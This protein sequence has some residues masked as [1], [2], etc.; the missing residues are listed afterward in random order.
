MRILHLNDRLSDRG[1]ADIYMHGIIE[2]LVDLHDVH[3]AVSR[4]ENDFSVPCPVT[5][6]D[7]LDSQHPVSVDLQPLLDRFRPDVIHLHN[8]VN[9]SVLEQAA[10]WP[11]VMTIHDHRSFCPGR[12]KL[13]LHG[14]VCR[15]SISLC[16]CPG[17]FTEPDYFQGRYE[18]TRQRLE[19]ICKLRIIVL[20]RYMNNELVAAG[21]PEH[22]LDIIPPFVHG[23]D[24]DARAASI[25]CILFA[26]RLVETKGIIPAIEAWKRAEVGLPLV[27]AGTGSGRNKLEASGHRVTGWLDRNTLSAWYRAAEV[28]VFPPLWQEPFGISGLESLFFGTSV[29]AW[30]SGG[31]AEWHPDEELLVEWGDIDA[32]AEAIRKGIGRQT[33]LPTKFAPALLMEQL[34]G[35]YRTISASTVR[36]GTV[37]K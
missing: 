30:Q 1:G 12:G 33:A 5:V 13:T 25:P 37:T 17:C 26:G 32:L 10:D 22:Q 14:Q 35:V 7:G 3:L 19:A 27:F 15:S 28:L 34:V 4:A 9:A 23:L 31:I 36:A 20:S 21:V 2:Q 16:R 6:I 29:A 8:I 18:V 24:L 11:A